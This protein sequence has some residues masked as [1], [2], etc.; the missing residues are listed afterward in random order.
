MKRD[1]IKRNRKKS[2]CAVSQGNKEGVARGG[3]SVMRAEIRV[4]GWMERLE[5]KEMMK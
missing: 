5:G 1:K 2:Q 3:S 4:L